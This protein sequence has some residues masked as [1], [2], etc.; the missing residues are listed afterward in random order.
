MKKLGRR[1]ITAIAGLVGFILGIAAF[2][3]GLSGHFGHG[4]YFY[5]LA[6]VLTAL[7]GVAAGDAY[8]YRRLPGMTRPTGTRPQAATQTTPS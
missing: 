6:A 4:T 3:V 1:W 8:A 5:A 2:G 7:G